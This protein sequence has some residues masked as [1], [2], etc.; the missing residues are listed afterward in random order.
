LLK[1]LKNTN[2]KVRKFFLKNVIFS[3]KKN[4]S[5]SYLKQKF[6]QYC[7]LKKKKKRNTHFLDLFGLVMGHKR[8]RE[9][10]FFRFFKKISESNLDGCKWKG[11]NKWIRQFKSAQGERRLIVFLALLLYLKSQLPMNKMRNLILGAK[12]NQFFT[13]KATVLLKRNFFSKTP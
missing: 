1:L 3:Q 10:D 8:L 11:L 13:D 2:I 12:N 7:V 4:F 5:I 6:F 9:E